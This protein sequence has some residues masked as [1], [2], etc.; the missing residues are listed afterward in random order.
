MSKVIDD[1]TLEKSGAFLSHW[2]NK[3]WL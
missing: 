3:E 1:L 2:G